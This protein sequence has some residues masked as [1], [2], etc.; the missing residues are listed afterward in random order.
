MTQT[1]GLRT[2]CFWN[3]RH[4]SD[5]SFCIIGEGIRGKETSG[6]DYEA[7]RQNFVA[8]LNTIPV[9]SLVYFFDIHFKI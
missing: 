6:M 5:T 1:E 2:F 7:S 4:F 8:K 3:L 9:E